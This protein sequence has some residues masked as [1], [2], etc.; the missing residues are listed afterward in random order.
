MNAG[1]GPGDPAG[2]ATSPGSSVAGAPWASGTGLLG[3]R[4]RSESHPSPLA[5]CSRL[6]GWLR[7]GPRRD[8]VGASAPVDDFRFV[9]LVAGVLGGGEARGRA[10]GT[11][12]VDHATAAAADEVVVVVADAVLVAG[13]RPGRLDAPQDALVG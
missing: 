13:R 10:D 11:V 12:D 6:D 7:R 2:S 3:S 5:R 9:D 4:S 1:G 8:A